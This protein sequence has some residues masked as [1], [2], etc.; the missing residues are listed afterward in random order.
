MHYASDLI[1]KDHN[2]LLQDVRDFD[3]VSDFT[4][5]EDA[6]DLLALDDRA[7]EAV[8]VHVLGDNLTS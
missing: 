1:D 2:F 8:F 3:E 5:S 6:L 7:E 4:E